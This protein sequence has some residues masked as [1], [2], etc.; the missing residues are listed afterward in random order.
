MDTCKV[1]GTD[2]DDVVPSMYTVRGKDNTPNTGRVIVK[3]ACFCD[4]C[5]EDFE[6][7]IGD[8]S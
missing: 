6:S 8:D 7:N 4:R 2:S 3:G 1:C 5:G